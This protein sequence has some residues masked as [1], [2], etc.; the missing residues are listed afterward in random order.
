MRYLTSQQESN[1][2]LL[3]TVSPNYQIIQEVLNT[4][5]KCNYPI[6]R[7]VRI[8]DDN[9]LF[10]SIY[11]EIGWTLQQFSSFIGCGVRRFCFCC[12]LQVTSLMRET[13]EKGWAVLV[14]TVAES[15]KFLY[16]K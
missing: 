12:V 13:S 1:V 11:F 9:L 6:R 7:T 14:L 8:F 4:R 3:K 15:E 5:S 2:A 10:K 16:S